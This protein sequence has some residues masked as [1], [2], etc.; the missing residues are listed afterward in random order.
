MS[1]GKLS[2]TLSEYKVREDGTW[3]TAR[4]GVTRSDSSVGAVTGRVNNSSSTS[5]ARAARGVDYTVPHGT[6]TS[7]TLTWAS[8]ESGTKFCDFL[9]INDDFVE[10]DEFLPL[11]LNTLTG[12]VTAGLIV[13]TRLII[14][15]DDFVIA[16]HRWDKT[17]LQ[18]EN[19]DGTWGDAVQLKGETGLPGLPG[20]PGAMGE[21]G[22]RGLTGVRGDRGDT[23]LTG[24]TGATGER[25]L[26]GI[27]GD[28]G[29]T[30]L[31][32]ATGQTGLKGERGLEGA[33]GIQGDRGLQGPQGTIGLQGISGVKGDSIRWR[34]AWNLSTAYLVSD[35]IFYNGSSYVAVVAN[36]NTLP[37]VSAMPGVSANWML[38]AQQGASAPGPQCT[39]IN[40]SLTYNGN[41]LIQI[42]LDFGSW[43]ILGITG[44]CHMSSPSQN[45]VMPPGGYANGVPP[46]SGV[47]SQQ[48]QTVGSNN[49]SLAAGS[50]AIQI[51]LRQGAFNIGQVM[52]FKILVWH[53]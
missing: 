21:R 12:G 35:G 19:A 45:W 8:G 37:G 44:T 10:G 20:L 34:G 41:N 5:P 23:G 7:Q 48:V 53:D 31:T 4:L 33:D 26:T 40:S 42:P 11:T 22:E 38:L 46:I 47:A 1:A 39:I 15:D 32:G 16:K 36:T 3:V 13:A 2:F 27:K 24:A 18:F 25:G 50:S 17:V 49:Y 43:H 9:I 29:D 51:I 14:L 30:G 28:R 52:I 6:G